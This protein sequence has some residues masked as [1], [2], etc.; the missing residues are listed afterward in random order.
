MVWSLLVTAILQTGTPSLQTVARAAISQ[1]DV[2]EQ[3][4]ARTQAEW[5]A[6]WR[7]HS[8]SAAPPAVDFASRTV[9]A[10]FLGSRST[11]GFQVEITGTR[12]KGGVVTVLWQEG[13]PA[14]DAVTAQVLTSPFHIVTIPKPAGD[15]RFEKV[16]R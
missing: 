8:P 5:A 11:A 12:E 14:A 9:A 6:L 1:I 15:I 3:S 16:P 4:V 13:R 7:R 10:V 2:A